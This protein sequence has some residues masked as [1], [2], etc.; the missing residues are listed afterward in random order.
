MID[1]GGT[2]NAPIDYNVTEIPSFYI[3]DAS[4]ELVS[5]TKNIADLPRMI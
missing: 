5:S 2:S 4:G 1:P 3:Y